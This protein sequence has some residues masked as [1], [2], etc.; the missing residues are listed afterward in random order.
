VIPLARVSAILRCLLLW[1]SWLALCS[2]TTHA[3]ED[4]K[5]SA[6]EYE[7]DLDTKATT[8]RGNVIVRIGT[9]ELRADEV[10]V[11]PSKN[12]IVAKGQVRVSEGDLSIEGRSAETEIRT[13][14]GSFDYGILRKGQSLYV[15]GR[16]LRSLGGNRY[17][18]SN[19]KVSFC[20]DCPQSWSVFGTS[21][22]MEIEGYVEIH[23]AIFQIKDQPVAY[24]PIFYFPIKR[25]RQSGFLFP[26]FIYSYDLGSQFVQ[27]YF[28]AIGP[29][30]DATIAYHYM[31][32]GGHRVVTEYRYFY[33][34]RSFFKGRSSYNRNLFVK[35]VKDNRYGFSLEE[36]Y[37]IHPNWTQRFKGEFAS[38]TRYSSDFGR[39]FEASG[40]P[41]LSSKLSLAY[42]NDWSVSYLQGLWNADNLPRDTTKGQAPLGAVHALP[43]LRLGIPSLALLG[44]LR[45]ETELNHLS[46]RRR[47][48]ALDPV[49]N[50][51][52]EGDRSTLL[53][54]F[55][56]PL[57]F[58]DVLS[59]E[60]R[61]RTRVD[62]Y[63]FAAEPFPSSAARGRV[64]LEER[65]STQ[66]YRVYE[67]DLGALKAIRH[68][69]EPVV[70][71]G[72]APNDA[73]TRHPFFSQV[74]DL[75]DGRKNLPSPRFDIF[76]P[77]SPELLANLGTSA[78]E[79]RLRPHHLLSLGLETRFVGR[80]D[81]EGRRE[82]EQLL[83]VSA[84]QDYDIKNEEPQRVNIRAVGS[85]AGV[86]GST[87]IA[88]DV[89]TGSAN[90]R[91]EL[92]LSRSSVDVNVVQ[93]IR[94]EL[95]SYSG[96]INFKFLR[97][98]RLFYGASY[99]AIS[100]NFTEQTL[101]LRYESSKSKCWFVSLDVERRPDRDNP[102]RTLTRYWP[103]VGLII[104]EAGVHF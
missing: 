7:T 16:K 82:Y 61:F 13:S 31:T 6:D 65:L 102:N 99:D 30:Q 52:R 23:H 77:T 49:T 76:D 4:L 11:N 39:D 63:Q 101:H 40:L 103:R 89:K 48:P 68:S 34:D 79:L 88:L 62:A 14:R 37:Q 29:D 67:S 33:S 53:N 90:L 54:T 104:N 44:P 69:W 59:L 22:E 91:N 19:G 55:Y 5:F 94:P 45:V 72:Y 58:Y 66:L 100:D 92:A 70:S 71:W 47:G 86:T 74:A 32:Q 73:M 85:Y 25:K 24:F 2:T 21:I 95:E 64:A 38:D 17:S 93:S 35:N 42:Q 83:L 97:P 10:I 36:R 98:M 26:D 9:R 15:E 51:I 8:A 43:E 50:W 1:G 60:S 80:F 12:L 81:R 3:A 78:E 27:P 87:E 18:I 84:S 56:L 46:L 28:W 57:Y 96:S 75:P 20:M 41:T